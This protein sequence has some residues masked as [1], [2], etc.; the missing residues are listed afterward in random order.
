[1]NPSIKVALEG[2]AYA[3]LDLEQIQDAILQIE[4]LG[5]ASC[6]EDSNRAHRVQP[7]GKPPRLLG[8]DVPSSSA[9]AAAAAAPDAH[10]SAI[11]A[12]VN[13]GTLG[14]KAVHVMVHLIL[15]ARL[16]TT[17]RILGSGWAIDGDN[18][19]RA[20]MRAMGPPAIVGG[21]DDQLRNLPMEPTRINI[22]L[23]RI[24]TSI[25]ILRV[26]LLSLFVC[27]S[28]SSSRNSYA[29][30]RKSSRTFLN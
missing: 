11:H 29:H 4:S 14:P 25:S 9:S 26:T 20:V 22:E 18:V 5:L 13:N 17:E 3:H 8:Q 23:V 15:S 6:T 30:C 16:K 10:L 12:A 27:S 19:M 21:L 2:P 28:F 1:M 7:L 24:R